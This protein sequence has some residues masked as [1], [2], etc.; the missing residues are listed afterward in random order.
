MWLGLAWLYKFGFALTILCNDSVMCICIYKLFE[1][2]I[3]NYFVI[4]NMTSLSSQEMAPIKLEVTFCALKYSFMVLDPKSYKM[5]RMWY[6]VYLMA[7]GE[8]PNGMDKYRLEASI[9]W[10]QGNML[11]LN[12]KDFQSI[13]SGHQ[14]HEID[15]VQLYLNPLPYAFQPP[16]SQ[17]TI[18][19]EPLFNS[20]LSGNPKD[21]VED[22]EIN[23]SDSS[24]GTADID[25]SKDD[26]TD[27]HLSKDESPET[28]SSNSKFVSSTFE[29]D[30]VNFSTGG[31]VPSGHRASYG[32]VENICRPSP[33]PRQS[34]V[35]SPSNIFV[36]SAMQEPALSDS[37]DNLSD[38]ASYHGDPND[39]LPHSASSDSD[40]PYPESFNGRIFR[41]EEE[42]KILLQDGLLFR[43]AHHFRLVFKD[44]MIQEGFEVIR[45]KSKRDRI[46][47]KCKANGC[48]WRIHVSPPTS[49]IGFQIKT[50]LDRHECQKVHHNIE[51][52]S[53]WIAKKFKLMIRNNP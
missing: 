53:S 34:S 46:T 19:V 47:A 6:T 12:D 4:R 5:D 40:A 27:I 37:D 11:I 45:V 32:D 23:Q 52:T 15:T 36:H 35:P 48:P 16:I 21:R 1:V 9:P 49:R 28:Y 44:Y 29:S 51:A 31:D 26:N 20:V 50:L 39:P 13:I 33:Q 17:P 14:D 22:T 43:S 18:I 7:H 25:L 30:E 2:Y 38:V 42:A 3:L 41:D 10:N 8:P 24:D